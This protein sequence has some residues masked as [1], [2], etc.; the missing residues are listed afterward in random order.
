[1]GSSCGFGLASVWE[2][3]MAPV[4]GYEDGSGAV[5]A[6]PGLPCATAALMVSP[7][8]S[9]TPLQTGIPRHRA[10]ENCQRSLV[11]PEPHPKAALSF[12]VLNLLYSA[13]SK[14]SAYA[15][16]GCCVPFCPGSSCFLQHVPAAVLWVLP[17][18]YH[19]AGLLRVSGLVGKRWRI[20][21]SI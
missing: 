21:F 1:V 8:L 9:P 20:Y 14:Q 6:L 18:C 16:Q 11:A 12:S 19:Q 5:R 10:A 17:S 13:K 2:R 15:W 4:Q 7:R 3:S